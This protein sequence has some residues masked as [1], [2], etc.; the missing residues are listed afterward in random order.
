MRRRSSSSDDSVSAAPG[1]SIIGERIA[2]RGPV[3]GGAFSPSG[4]LLAFGDAAAI[5]VLDLAG[6][7]IERLETQPGVFDSVTFAPDGRTLA[8]LGWDDSVTLWERSTWSAG[9]S[10]PAPSPTAT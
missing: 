2:D 7:R 8:A 5:H 1:Q 3:T 9:N 4:T 6:T 10:V